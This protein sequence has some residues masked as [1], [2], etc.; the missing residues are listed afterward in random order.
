[1]PLPAGGW[2]PPTVLKTPFKPPLP[3]VPQRARAAFTTPI[4]Q[5]RNRPPPPAQPQQVYVK[6]EPGLSDV[7]MV[8]PDD[9]QSLGFEGAPSKRRRIAA[10]PDSDDDEDGERL[11]SAAEVMQARVGHLAMAAPAAG[12][13]HAPAATRPE[14][15]KSKARCVGLSATRD[16]DRDS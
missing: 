4:P 7:E 11:P 14:G 2:Q 16:R 9:G 5:P 3:M 1:M 8:G 10:D 15:S 6:P 12:P 13:S